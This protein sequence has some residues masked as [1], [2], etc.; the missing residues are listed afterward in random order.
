MPY[1][2]DGH[3]LIGQL[4]DISLDDPDDEA[5]LV[6]KLIGFAARTHKRCVVVFDQGLPGGR[7]RMSTSQVE[8][9]FASSRSNA[10]RVMIERISAVKDTGQWIV[11]SNDNAVLHAA[12]QRKMKAIKSIDFAAQ[13]APPE[14]KPR[15]DDKERQAD[16]HLSPDEIE[17][18]LRIF[19]GKQ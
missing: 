3:N 7:S 19:E 1:L 11:V 5:K 13:L 4:P 15:R 16:V 8:A 9:I 12:R 10:D 6:Q 18:W 2:I 14:P 17:E